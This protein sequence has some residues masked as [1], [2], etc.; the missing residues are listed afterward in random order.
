M[1]QIFHLSVSGANQWG[2]EEIREWD[3]VRSFC[4]NQGVERFSSTLLRV[5]KNQ[6]VGGRRYFKYGG[7]GNPEIAWNP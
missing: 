7:C 3:Q 5:V 4:L 1:R 6:V 2:N